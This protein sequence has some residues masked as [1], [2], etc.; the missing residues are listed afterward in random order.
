MNK[1]AIIGSVTVLVIIIIAAA[2]F[3]L[4]SANGNQHASTSVA[5][6]IS[7]QQNNTGTSKYTINVSYNPAVGNYLVN[8][9]GRTLYTYKQD[10]PNSG[11]SA[12]SGTCA[13]IWPAFYAPSIVVPAGLSAS[14][15]GTITRAD[16]TKQSTYD[17]LP[18]YLYSGDSGAGQINGQGVANFAVASVTTNSTK[19]TS[20]V[21]PTTIV[22]STAGP[23]TTAVAS[24][25]TAAPTTTVCNSY[26]G[27]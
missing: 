22:T 20:T 27:C 18:L 6:T 5:T 1:T 4:T 21:A 15:F 3:L 9:S 19:S 24:K 2:A 16:G 17:G 8:A 25:S 14:S 11:T 26:Y 13:S 7:T 12:C 23:T 10:T